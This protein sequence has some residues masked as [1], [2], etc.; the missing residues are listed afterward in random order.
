MSGTNEN[1]EKCREGGSR[2]SLVKTTRATS[3]VQVSGK[4]SIREGPGLHVVGICLQ[5]SQPE[6]KCPRTKA[7]FI[8]KRAFEELRGV[9]RS[10]EPH[11]RFAP[12]LRVG[13]HESDGP[14]GP[15]QLLPGS[16][17][18]ICHVLPP[19]AAS[20]P[21]VLENSA[22]RCTLTQVLQHAAPRSQWRGAQL[23]SGLFPQLGLSLMPHFPSALPCGAGTF[24]TF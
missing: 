18:S 11:F 21:L 16:G 5:S 24:F 7:L 2:P 22:T 4:V 6:P 23:H 13:K 17:A 12:H 8:P 15:R 14:A 10:Q 1:Q 3:Q 19:T 20:E 9:P